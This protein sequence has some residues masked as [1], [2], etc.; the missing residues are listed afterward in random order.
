MDFLNHR[1]GGMVFN[2]VFLIY[3][4]LSYKIMFY[5]GCG[6]KKCCKIL[7]F[8]PRLPNKRNKRFSS[9]LLYSVQ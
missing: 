5:P 8:R 6:I 2:Q 7:S 3:L 9:F 4:Y 1:E